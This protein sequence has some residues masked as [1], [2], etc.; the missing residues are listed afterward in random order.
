MTLILIKHAMPQVNP[1]RSSIEWEL[2]EDGINGSKALGEKLKAHNITRII[3][4]HEPKAIQTGTTAAQVL[5]V[6]CIARDNLH[7]HDRRGVPFYDKETFHKTV[8][9][10]FDEPDQL[11][12]GRETADAA[13]L[14]F[15][16]AVKAV[17]AE[18]PEDRLAIVA[19]GTVITLFAA[20]YNRQIKP[21]DFWKQLDLPSMVVL[22]QPDF[23]VEAVY[24]PI[25]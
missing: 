23:N 24:S 21:F 22:S 18:F 7:E 20:A 13:R 1:E 19:H 17:L 6:P 10:F 12:F 3:T 4:S 25:S 14:R 15:D 9:R 16:A 11:I 5:D 2:G 8:E